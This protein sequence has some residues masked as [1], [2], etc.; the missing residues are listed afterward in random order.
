MKALETVMKLNK[1]DNF[2]KL[3]DEK[4]EP[5]LIDAEWYEDTCRV[6]TFGAKKIH[7]R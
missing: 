5:S 3:D 2:I 7:K 6:L 1:S 4:I